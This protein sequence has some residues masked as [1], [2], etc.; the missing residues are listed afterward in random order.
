VKRN[1]PTPY[2]KLPGYTPYAPPTADLWQPIPSSTDGVPPAKSD[3]QLF[4]EEKTR[5]SNPNS[6]RTSSRLNSRTVN[7]HRFPGLGRLFFPPP[8]SKSSNLQSRHK[9]LRLVHPDPPIYVWD[10]FLSPADLAHI[11]MKV[12][13]SQNAA[14]VKSRHKL[15]LFNKSYTDNSSAR[16]NKSDDNRS[17][18]FTYFTKCEDNKI[19]AI[20]CR[21]GELLG[22]TMERVE[23]LQ[24][25]RYNVG[26]FFGVHHDTG[27]C[28]CQLCSVGEGGA[29]A[30]HARGGG[31]TEDDI[32]MAATG[33]WPPKV[34]GCVWA[35]TIRARSYRFFRKCSHL[36][37]PPSV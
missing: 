7:V 19:A 5:E 4:A 21:A 8:G 15:K 37:P 25:V 10:N 28:K 6:K 24:V 11:E 9:G 14:Q 16:R 22:T 17:S 23:P 27:V 31:A 2:Y 18:S 13:A 12:L 33:E 1:P 20:E 35:Y 26:Q 34:W 30:P 29:T 3:A 32:I 36:T